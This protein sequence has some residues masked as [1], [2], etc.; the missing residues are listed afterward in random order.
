MRDAVNVRAG[1]GWLHGQVHN[2]VNQTDSATDVQIVIPLD[3]FVR[4]HRACKS[5]IPFYSPPTNSRKDFY[6]RDGDYHIDMG[7]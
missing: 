7:G 5:E 4:K 3:D 6:G 1:F 2:S